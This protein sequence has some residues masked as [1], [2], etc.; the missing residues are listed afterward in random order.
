M[1]IHQRLD[2]VFVTAR[3]I[4]PG[5]Q[6]PENSHG[7]ADLE[8][9]FG[10]FDPS[11]A[12]WQAWEALDIKDIAANPSLPSHI[13][14]KQSSVYGMGDRW[15][16]AP[17]RPGLVE[18]FTDRM[19]SL[20]MEPNY[21]VI[22]GA[23]ALPG[24]DG[25]L[26]ADYLP[27]DPAV[28]DFESVRRR[29]IAEV[30]GPEAFE[31]QDVQNGKVI[32]PRLRDWAARETNIWITAEAA[33]KL[34][35][36][37]DYAMIWAGQALFP[38]QTGV[39]RS[40]VRSTGKTLKVNLIAGTQDLETTLIQAYEHGVRTGEWMH[41]R[42]IIGTIKQFAQNFEAAAQAADMVELYNTDGPEPILIARKTDSGAP[43]E[44]LDEFRF[45]LFEEQKHLD[46]A[47]KKLTDISS[48]H[49]I[50]KLFGPK[51]EPSA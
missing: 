40:E 5:D 17:Q 46:P 1:L 49:A 30:W 25:S 38:E 27:G 48:R 41:P 37:R 7:F 21:T 28:S 31:E 43:L 39:L 33:Y 44:I 2:P 10:A 11:P 45:H 13:V 32:D 29:I 3:I 34:A 8:R 23:Y 4:N 15:L 36:G 42:Q 47:K 18:R 12:P 26:L 50:Y 6:Y 19:L 14:T 22:G 9:V 20:Q 24:G 51:P 16:K 35:K